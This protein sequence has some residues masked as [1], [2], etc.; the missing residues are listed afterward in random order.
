VAGTKEIRTWIMGFG[1]LAKVLEPASLLKE[2]KAELG[3]SL[4]AYAKL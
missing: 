1:S 2:I 4:K 3:K